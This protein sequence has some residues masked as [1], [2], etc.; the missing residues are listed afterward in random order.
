MNRPGGALYQPRSLKFPVK[1][2][3]QSLCHYSGGRSSTASARGVTAP[4][5]ASAGSLTRSKHIQFAERKRPDLATWSP[6]RATLLQACQRQAACLGGPDT[7]TRQKLSL[8][9]VRSYLIF[10]VPESYAARLEI[11]RGGASAD[12][13]SSPPWC[14]YRDRVESRRRCPA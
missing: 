5:K 13:W 9:P 8:R 3:Q 14:G 12:L 11:A 6:S 1:Y 10:R 7:N 2:K 4:A